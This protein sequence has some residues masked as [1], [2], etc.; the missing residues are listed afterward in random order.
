MAMVKC[1]KCKVYFGVDSWYLKEI[2]EGREEQLC[3]KCK[4]KLIK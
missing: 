2:E 1:L 4:E 3:D